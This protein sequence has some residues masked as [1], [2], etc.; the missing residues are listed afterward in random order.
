MAAAMWRWAHLLALCHEGVHAGGVLL[1]ELDQVGEH[2]VHE[3]VQPCHLHTTREPSSLRQARLV[4]WLTTW[5]TMAADC[6]AICRGTSS[7]VGA[8]ECSVPSYLE[9]NVR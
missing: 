1:E 9:G 2:E 4:G 8:A 3:A 7:A 6:E 5:Q